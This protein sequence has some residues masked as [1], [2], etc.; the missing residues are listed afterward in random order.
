[1]QPN[2]FL[3]NPS[4]SNAFSAAATNLPPV[5][6]STS[7][8]SSSQ[9][10]WH[11]ERTSIVLQKVL[12][13][14][15]G[16]LCPLCPSVQ[17]PS[18]SD[19]TGDHVNRVCPAMH[20]NS[21]HFA[22]LYCKTCSPSI[23][24]HGYL[25][26]P[27]EQYQT[28]TWVRALNYHFLLNAR[29]VSSPVS[30][31]DV[32]LSY[33]WTYPF[34]SQ[35]SADCPCCSTG[36]RPRHG[37]SLLSFRTPAHCCRG[38]GVKHPRHSAGVECQPGGKNLCHDIAEFIWELF[39]IWEMWTFLENLIRSAVSCKS[40]LGTCEWSLQKSLQA[41]DIDFFAIHNSDWSSTKIAEADVDLFCF[42]SWDWQHLYDPAPCLISPQN[43]YIF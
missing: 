28:Q 13:H 3:C 39:R 33:L 26:P 6:Q 10:S 34:S 5:A 35:L 11:S 19:M 2:K 15:I 17:H 42:E 29:T 27:C 37:S 41:V 12:H 4:V 23:I 24:H 20:S 14:F 21:K 25:F 22:V 9:S 7:N 18:T 30:L 38:Y 31:H 40:K 16:T 1:M 32:F 8:G 36:A 43:M